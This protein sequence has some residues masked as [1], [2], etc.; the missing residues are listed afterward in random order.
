M[1]SLCWKEQLKIKNYLR[2]YTMSQHR[3]SALAVLSIEA[4]TVSKLDC[5][6]VKEFSK[7]N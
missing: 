5:D 1:Y 7:T 4:D 3:L 2:G 6:T